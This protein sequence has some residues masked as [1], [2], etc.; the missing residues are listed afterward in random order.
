MLSTSTLKWVAAAL[1][2]YFIIFIV[3]FELHSASLSDAHRHKGKS[4]PHPDR[5][6]LF[7]HDGV[8]SGS[9]EVGLTNRHNNKR[10]PVGHVDAAPPTERPSPLHGNA[11][12]SGKAVKP[13]AHAARGLD[14]QAPVAPHRKSDPKHAEHEKNARELHRRANVA[15]E[16]EHTP[17][18]AHHGKH[19]QDAQ[20]NNHNHPKHDEEP[21]GG[22]HPKVKN[23]GD[24][25]VPRAPHHRQHGHR[26]RAEHV[27]TVVEPVAFA[28][29]VSNEDFIDGALVMGASFWN[30]SH[31]VQIGNATLVAI[32]PEGAVGAESIERLRLAGWSHV[33]QVADLTKFA[34]PHAHYAATFNKLY[35]FNLT[36]Y[37][38]VATFDV[39]M[40][41]LRSPD[42][43]FGT[44]LQNDQ[45]IGAL[46]NSHKKN[47]SYFQTG[48]MLIA[49]SEKSFG[50]L[51]DEFHRNPRQR[52]MNGRDG[53]L[54]RDLFKD[55]YVN[56]D[57]ALS[58][59]LGVHEPLG[60]VI[61]FHYRG[62]FKPWF[63]KEHPPTKPAYGD[64]SGKILEQELGEAYRR[65]WAAYEQ[66]HHTKLAEHDLGPQRASDAPAGYD[67]SR[68]VWL[69]RHTSRSYIQLLS[70][71][72]AAER[73]RT[74]PGLRIE[75]AE[76]G[77]SCDEACADEQSIC[78]NDALSFGQIN[79]C[80]LLRDL[81]GCEKCSVDYPG[82]EEPAYD[83]VTR[84]CYKN[85][86]DYKNQRPLC[87][88][89]MAGHER[90]CPCLP[91]ENAYDHSVVYVNNETTPIAIMPRL[92][93][94]SKVVLPPLEPKGMHDVSGCFPTRADY[95]GAD[96]RCTAYLKN[97]DNVEWVSVLGRASLVGRTVKMLLHYKEP[98]IKAVVKFPQK[99]FPH[100]AQSEFASY[101]VDRAIGVLRVPPTAFTFIPLE[102]L[103]SALANATAQ[104]TDM[105]MKTSLAGLSVD[106]FDFLDQQGIGELVRQR[107]GPGRSPLEVGAS[108]QLWMEDLHSLKD[109]VFSDAAAEAHQHHKSSAFATFFKK[110]GARKSSERTLLEISRML[111]LDF[112]VGNDDRTPEKNTF[113]LGGC[114]GVHCGPGR[115]R[116]RFEGGHPQMALVD[117]G[118]S[119]YFSGNPEDNALSGAHAD[120]ICVFSKTL[121]SNCLALSHNKTSLGP[122]QSNRSTAASEEDDE[123]RNSHTLE[124]TLFRLLP[125]EVQ[126]VLHPDAIHA[127]QDRLERL[128]N[129]I[130]ACIGKRHAK[131]VL[132]P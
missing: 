37:H 12:H 49:P 118:R 82:A 94:G 53:R 54:I 78:K 48:M 108:V 77:K 14:T 46:G 56:L 114:R 91:L 124:R 64:K 59:H 43:V 9:E 98:N 104:N 60:N 83:V 90:L 92:K 101:L 25:P 109:S 33:Q 8:P 57:P 29:V 55:R 7:P 85:S 123:V 99:T 42:G 10:H 71:V 121:I 87:N 130:D 11:L 26:H 113:V 30:Q 4:H 3:K 13:R 40:L 100:E 17:A 36:Q 122:L 116:F 50:W 72:D 47:H 5:S 132:R 76:S 129:H 88:A 117:Q 41:M 24:H 105:N 89:S 70:V 35:L 15:L 127:A 97:L 6:S 112:I 103:R 32:V 16:A 67:P 31:L 80:E 102:M 95:F 38:R 27:I 79:N 131:D 125:T 73:N 107:H 1:I 119:F 58:A 84:V 45:W 128:L 96:E 75:I 63:D 21:V 52:D 2:L 44:S 69:M 68:H 34:A 28:V 111:V 61:G 18:P 120:D 74:Y 81:F 19:H 126:K 20:P 22:A 86:L 51:M 65:W 106:L 23:G 115:S 62:E 39:D 66:L 93:S 110:H